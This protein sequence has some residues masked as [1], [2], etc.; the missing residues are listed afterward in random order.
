MPLED[1]QKCFVYE[2]I[3]PFGDLRG[4]LQAGII[5]STVANIS[6]KKLEKNMAPKDFMPFFQEKPRQQ[7]PEEMHANFLMVLNAAK[8]RKPS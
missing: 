5:A 6:G 8:K 2:Q 7:T 4:D 1:F 3:E